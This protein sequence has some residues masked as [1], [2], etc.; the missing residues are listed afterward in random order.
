M[1]PSKSGETSPPS[2][3]EL[4]VSSPQRTKDFNET[5]LSDSRCTSPTHDIEAKL[6]KLVQI[7]TS[8]TDEL[9]RMR[10]GQE[11]LRLELQELRI[12]QERLWTYSGLGTS[13]TQLTVEDQI[14]TGRQGVHRGTPRSTNS[15]SLARSASTP[16]SILANSP[17]RLRQNGEQT[18]TESKL[19][20]GSGYPASSAARRR[21]IEEEQRRNMGVDETF[22]G[23]G[24][25][26]QTRSGRGQASKEVD[27]LKDAERG[28]LYGL[29]HPLL[30][31]GT[32]ERVK[33]NALAQVEAALNRGESPNVWAGPGSPL[34]SA[35]KARNID[36]VCLLLEHEGDPDECDNK[37]VSL[38]HMAAYDG[39]LDICRLLLECHG[40]PNISDQYGQTPLFFTPTR[41][42]CDLLYK[43]YADVNVMN[44]Q[45]QSALHLAARAGLGDVLA[46]LSTRVTK[47]LLCLR[48]SQGAFATDYARSAGV[49]R[50]VILKLEKASDGGLT[51]DACEQRRRKLPG[52][53]VVSPGFA[54]MAEE[55]AAR[56]HI[57]PAS[58][59]LDASDVISLDTNPRQ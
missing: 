42:I 15:P 20:Q 4:R 25:V 51:R 55:S 45:G 30:R 50:E 33:A 34:R 24:Y 38:M 52:P 29:A 49:R 56:G 11:A 27:A 57:E 9:S 41:S 19:K 37:R 44:N 5:I 22:A 12:D 35:V 10:I 39:Q 7:V 36:L 54:T 53:N 17:S 31:A 28:G 14:D 13:E 18:R 16:N 21:A 58:A 47:A 43:A 8:Q 32:K 48:D 46:W 1:V 6:D 26:A 3:P 40:D 59:T 23:Q 2:S